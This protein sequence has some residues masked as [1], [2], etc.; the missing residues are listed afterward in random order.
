VDSEKHV[1]AE[2]VLDCEK[3]IPLRVLYVSFTLR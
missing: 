3:K 1:R 2:K